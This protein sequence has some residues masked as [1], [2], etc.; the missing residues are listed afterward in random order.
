MLS[1]LFAPS[2]PLDETS[3]DWIFQVF[4]WSLRNLDGAYFRDHTILVNPTN[5]HFA[6]R[7]NSVG[8]MAELIFRTVAGYA[9][10]AHWPLRLIEATAVM[11]ALTGPVTVNGP[12]RAPASQ[13]RPPASSS[14][15]LTVPYDSAL[16]ANPEALIAGL[17]QNLAHRLG[18]TVQEPPPGGLENWPQTTEVIGVVL[19]FGLM[20]A[21]TAFE[22]QSRSCGSCGGPAAR[23]E[24]F[25]SQ[26]DITYA[27]ALF[28]TLKEIPD[29]DVLRH[30]KSS[31]RGHYKRCV[32]DLRPRTA[33]LEALHAAA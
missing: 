15:L 2:P 4:G 11:P 3:V 1:N 12:L 6:G 24:A 23:R 19:G 33:A 26:Y 31:L 32:R 27:L 5:E 25:L 17:A 13:A 18:A 8:G 29:R 16:V 20:F 14:A 21:N 22:F 10:M 30:L 7:T 9:G 28:A